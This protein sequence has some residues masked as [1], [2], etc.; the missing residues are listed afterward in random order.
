MAP[1]AIIGFQ[2]YVAD[3]FDLNE[4]TVVSSHYNNM[5]R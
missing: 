5:D 1:V 4:Q 2:C 3:V